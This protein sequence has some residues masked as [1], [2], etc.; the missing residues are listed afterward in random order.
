MCI[1]VMK[2]FEGYPDVGAQGTTAFDIGEK[3]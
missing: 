3:F 2:D 1:T